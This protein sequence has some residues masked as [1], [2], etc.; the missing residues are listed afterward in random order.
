MEPI[1]FSIQISSNSKKEKFLIALQFL[2]IALIGCLAVMNFFIVSICLYVFVP[3]ILWLLHKENKKKK[4]HLMLFS[5]RSV[6]LKE[7][8]SSQQIAFENIEQIDIRFSSIKGDMTL[9]KL[10]SSGKFNKIKIKTTDNKT[11]VRWIWLKT[12]TDYIRLKVLGRFLKEK[13][14]NIKMRGFIR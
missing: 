12:D 6:E 5:E 10:P 8:E 11:I 13:E 2:H 1:S 7:N 14:I 9:R 3:I 4:E